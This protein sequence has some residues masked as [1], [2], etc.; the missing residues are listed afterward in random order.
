MAASAAMID[1]APL[2]DIQDL[3]VA[4]GP[5]VALD[6]LSARLPPGGIG[7]LGPNGAGKTT[8][9]RAMLG[10][11]RASAGRLRVLGLDP[12]EQP[13]EVRR[14]IGYMPE[15]DAFVAGLHAAGFVAYAGELSGLPRDEAVSRAHEMLDYVGLGEARYRAVETFSTGMKQR[16]KL[17]QALVHDPELLLLDEP[18]SGL[19]PGGRDE[20]LA[21]LADIVSR[22]GMSVVLSSHLLPDVERVCS[23]VLVIDEGHVK[24][25]GPLQSLVRT[26]RAV[27]EVRLRGDTAAFVTDLRDAGGDAHLIDDVW[28]VELP[29]GKGPELVFSVARQA[30]VQVRHLRPSLPSLED[31]FL[32]AVGQ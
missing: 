17:A 26:R 25:Q 29:P 16:V 18:T 11:V 31:V 1:E 12:A 2:L 8:L 24:A 3:S 15:S 21:L 5:V 32:K 30:G 28:R 19:D 23:S 13:L 4:Y 10:F 22:L 9:L 7:L 20:M 14:R 27:Y 6:G